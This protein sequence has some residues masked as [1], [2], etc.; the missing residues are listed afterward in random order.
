M[1]AREHGLDP[2]QMALAFVTGRPFVTAN[3]IGATTM[4]QLRS[5][6]ASSETKLSQAVLDGIDA[7]HK[8]YT[9]PCP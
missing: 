9:Y 6:I 1:L 7:I 4:E 2:A 8:V 3:I 5:N